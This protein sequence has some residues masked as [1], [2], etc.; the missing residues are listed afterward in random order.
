MDTETLDRLLMDRALGSLPADTDALL[1]AYLDYD[2]AAGARAREFAAAAA[3]ARRL[4]QQPLP[5][6]LP[7]FP[8]AN[9]RNVEQAQRRVRALRYIASMAAVL[10][11]GIGLGLVFPH[12]P[13]I[14]TPAP[15]IT[16]V[17]TTPVVAAHEPEAGFWSTQRLYAN[18][19]R[20]AR[21]ETTHLIWNSTT[22]LPR[23]GEQL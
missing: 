23:L 19:R 13:A 18:V 1:V 8:A 12:A 22:A 21:P 7:P 4:F 14:E 9:I 3:A 11:V 2:K 6:A 16:V 20:A 17:A 10:V 15:L 5:T